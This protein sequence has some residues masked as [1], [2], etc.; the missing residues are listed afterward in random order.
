[1]KLCGRLQGRKVAVL[2]SNPEACARILA[3]SNNK[4]QGIESLLACPA[5]QPALS[6]ESVDGDDWEWM[7]TQ[8]S[9]LY[10]SLDTGPQVGRLAQDY[11]RAFAQIEDL[12]LDGEQIS[13]LTSKIMFELVLARKMTQAENDLFYQASIEWRKEI[14]IKGKASLQIKEEFFLQLE[15]ILSDSI[16]AEDLAANVENKQR[17]VSLFAQPLFISPQIN[18][19]DIFASIFHYLSK[20][21]G[22]FAKARASAMNN[23]LEALKNICLE[24]IR[25]NHPFP[26]LE[27]QLTRKLKIMGQE[28]EEGTHAYILLDEFEQDP[29][30]DPE[31]WEKSKVNPYRFMP[32]GSGQRM[33]LGKDLALEMLGQMLLGILQNIPIE[34][35]RP[36]E[37]HQYSG[38]DNDGKDTFATTLYQLKIF[39]GALRSSFL[40]GLKKKPPLKCP[41]GEGI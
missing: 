39:L 35:I 10:K 8:F 5:W 40:L 7:A 6:I 33:C 32:F 38:R 19:S 34:K 9:Q 30:F 2:N 14:A 15:R 22:L 28:W 13:R 16:Y 11:L 29:E 21:Q 4:G 31:R 24:S 3:S 1:M 36:G 20:D 23:D 18:F 25:L 37:N 27:R 26:V 17:Y 41:H 12:V